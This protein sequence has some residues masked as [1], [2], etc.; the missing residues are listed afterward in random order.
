M[1]NT[2]IPNELLSITEVLSNE[3]KSL[4]TNSVELVNNLINIT[5]NE[6]DIIAVKQSIRKDTLD[7]TKSLVKDNRVLKEKIKNEAL[8]K[9]LEEINVKAK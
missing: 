9:S 5:N 8:K 3:S 2:T 1:T 4:V 6:L 7:A